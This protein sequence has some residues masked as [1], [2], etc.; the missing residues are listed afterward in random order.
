MN[1]KGQVKTDPGSINFSIG[2]SRGSFAGTDVTNREA[3]LAAGGTA[4]VGTPD[5]LTLDGAQLSGNRVVVD[6]GSLAIAS[7]QDTSTYAS[8]DKSAGLSVSFT[9]ATGQVSGGVNGSSAR[10]AGDFAS[11]A[12]QAGIAAGS[13]GFAINVAGNTDLKGAVIAS[14]A[15]AARNQLTTGTLSA[16]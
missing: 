15:E 11:V 13:G 8:K 7:R 3:V 1:A 9:P 2:G 4:R 14:T 16:S 5:Q 10:Q 12:E 6:A